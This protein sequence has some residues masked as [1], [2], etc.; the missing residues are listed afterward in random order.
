MKIHTALGLVAA[1]TAST[2]LSAAPKK[3]G[4]TYTDLKDP[5]LPADYQYQ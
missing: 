2:F 3:F 4:G 5:N 1:M